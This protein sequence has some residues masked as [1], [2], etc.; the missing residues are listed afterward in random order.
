[1]RAAPALA[2]T[3]AV[4]V[5]GLAGFYGYRH[6]AARRHAPLSPATAPAPGASAG[7][8]GATADG[9]RPVLKVP[10]T[11]PEVHLAGL[12]GRK[13]ALAEFAH[14]PLIV[15]F[16]ATWC[17]PC[18]REIPLLTTLRSAY[19]GD[20][21]EIVGIAI[22]FRD[23][24]DAFLK[25]TPL[26]YPLLIG[27]EDGIDAAAAFGMQVVLPFSVFVDEQNR[28]VAVK[29]GE[30]HRD[31]ADAILGTMRAVRAGQLELTAARARIAEKLK[32]IATERALH[33]AL[34]PSG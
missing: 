3:I 15:N 19:A 16:W 13:H 22:D 23:S 20:H 2:G 7:A 31:E 27:E 29:V 1:M 25:K 11:L 8:P 26:P 17:E 9:S 12:D 32:A 4:L 21:L 24:V 10:D 33:G 28:I 6:Y 30:L 18:R 5:G 34:A 14:R